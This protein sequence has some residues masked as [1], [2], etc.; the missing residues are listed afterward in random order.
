MLEDVLK[1]YGAVEE[2]PMELYE[3]VF[4][5]GE[6]LIQRSGEPPGQFK[7]NPII[8]GG[9]GG[10]VRRRVMFEDTFQETLE[11]FCG[12]E[13]AYMGG[14]TYFGRRNVSER[15][16]KLCALIFDIDD[17]DDGRLNNLL[18]AAYSEI[19]DVYPIPQHVVLSG[20][21]IH[22]YYVLEE[23]L[24]LYPNVKTQA[25]ELKYALTRR[26]WNRYTSGIEDVQY[27]GINQSFRVPGSRTKEGCERRV[28]KAFRLSTHPTTI[29]EL[30]RFVPEESRVDVEARYRESRMTAEE[31]RSRYPEWYER[32]VEGSVRE[33]WVVKRDLY[34]WWLRR[35][36]SDEVSYGHRYFCV[37]ALAVFAAKCGIYDKSKVREDAMGLLGHF[38]EV[39]P[40]N[41]FTEDDIESALDCLDGRYATFPRRD[42]EKLTAI[43]MPANKR[44]GRKQKEH[45]AVMRAIQSVVDPEGSWRNKRG[46]PTKRDL[47]RAYALE[48]PDANHSEAARAL[49]V[50][51][52]TVIKW[53]KPGWREEWERDHA[54]HIAGSHLRV[55]HVPPDV[56]FEVIRDGNGPGFDSVRVSRRR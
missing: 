53:L 14:C 27:Q 50:S 40:E 10:R 28:C 16:S 12:L 32:V 6:G 55:E 30:N 23:P 44:N 46:A 47:V 18:Y 36:A 24:S 21:G 41:P 43:P 7:A 38:N 26:L 20:H 35:I 11:E 51:R 25:K 13:W 29:E 39:S 15:Q 37:M 19:V 22:L 3:D 4:R 48:H 45:M 34:D 5:L 33:Q 52:P 1:R 17:V 42:L 54:P 31:A 49:G 9:S 56:F 8:I 2:S